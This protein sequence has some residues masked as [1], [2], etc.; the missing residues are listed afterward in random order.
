MFDNKYL[1]CHDMAKF[2]KIHVETT[3]RLCREGKIP[4]IKFR[5]TW[6][7]EVNQLRL[8]KGTYIPFPGRTRKSVNKLL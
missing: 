8:F 2:L 5:N 7:C 4:A 6:L 1:D 3:K